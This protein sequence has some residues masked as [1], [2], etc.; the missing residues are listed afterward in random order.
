MLK[1]L[2]CLLSLTLI[3]TSV[4]PSLAQ[5]HKLG[6][7][8]KAAQQMGS[9]VTRPAA[10]HV[11]SGSIS[12]ITKK[13]DKTVAGASR[14][15]ART[16]ITPSQILNT[17]TQRFEPVH[18]HLLPPSS[19][20]TP[21]AVRIV[22]HPNLPERNLLFRSDFPLLTLNFQVQPAELGKALAVYREGLQTIS[23]PQGA[24][25]TAD[26]IT[27]ITDRVADV[28]ALGITGEST[29]DASLILATFEKSIGTAA[30]PLMTAVASRA[31]LNLSA[32]EELGRMSALSSQQPEL[33]EGIEKYAQERGLPITVASRERQAVDV[34][35]FQEPMQRYGALH[36][37]AATPDM[38]STF[39]LMNG[40]CDVVQ[41]ISNGPTLPEGF[42][43][44]GKGATS[45]VTGREDP[46]YA[47]AGD[48]VA[49]TKPVQPVMPQSVAPITVSSSS[50]SAAVPRYVPAETKDPFG[51]TVTTWKENSEHELAQQPPVTASGKKVGLIPRLRVSAASAFTAAHLFL[52]S[53]YGAMGMVAGISPVTAEA[54]VHTAPSVETVE[55]IRTAQDG[56]ISVE[57][58]T[59]G[60]SGHARM[61]VNPG[62]ISAQRAAAQTSATAKTAKPETSAAP[63]TNP[64]VIGP[65]SGI[66]YSSILGPLPELLRRW[67]SKKTTSQTAETKAKG[68]MQQANK[69]ARK[70]L[71]FVQ[72]TPTSLRAI[73]ESNASKEYKMDALLRLYEQGKLNTAING[74]PENAKAAFE[75][76]K[77]T[78]KLKEWLYNLYEMG[79]LNFAL[80]NLADHSVQ[81]NWEQDLRAI[82]ED[83]SWASKALSAYTNM[84]VLPSTAPGV[85]EGV[86]PPVP[87]VQQKEILSTFREGGFAIE[88]MGTPVDQKDVLY[89]ANRIPFYYRYADGRLSPTPVGI[90]SQESANWYGRFLSNIHLASQPGFKIP[91]G[92]VLALDESGQWKFIPA[93]GELATIENTPASAKI[94]EQIRK[95]GSYHV[96]LDTP[97]TSS[98]LLSMANMLET[99][100]DLNLELVLNTP[101]SLQQ[102]LKVHAFFIGNDAGMSLAGPFTKMLKSLPNVGA[103]MA[104]AV[105]GVGYLTPWIA[106]FAMPVMK[107]LGNVKTIQAVYGAAAAALLA[108][109]GMGLFW[110]E[111]PIG[112]EGG[113]PMGMLAVPTVA[114][115]LGASLLNTFNNT[116]LNF[117][118]DPKTRTSAHLSFAENK[119]WSRLA[120]TGLTAVAAALGGSWAVVVPV[121]LGLLAMSE[122]LFI[123]TPIY[124]ARNVKDAKA[125]EEKKKKEITAE[126]RQAFQEAYKQQIAS[127]PE[128]KDIKFRV[129]MVYASYAASLL[130]LGQGATEI[131]GPTWGPVMAAVFM[132]GTAL[133]RKGASKAIAKNKLTDD[134]MT[135]ISLPLLATSGIALTLMPY[136]GPMAALTALVGILHYMAT[137]TPGQM[138]AARLQN[139]VSA[140]MQKQKAKVLA[141]ESLTQEERSALLRELSSQEGEWASTA[142]KQ[143]SYAN[144][145]GLAGIT[146]AAAAAYLFRDLGPQWTKEILEFI[147]NYTIGTTSDSLG[148]ARIIFGYSATMASILAAKNIPLFKDFVQIFHKQQITQEN[149]D[150]GKINPSMFGMNE[151]NVALRLVNVEKE[152]SKLQDGMIEYG[153]SSE[154][155]LTKY[156]Q[157]L[158]EIYNRLVAANSLPGGSELVAPHMNNLTEL[159]RRYEGILDRNDHS[160]MLQRAFEQFKNTMF[161]ENG[162][163][164][165]STQYVEE[166]VYT[167]PQDYSKY[168]E[169]RDLVREIKQLILHDV[170]GGQVTVD[171]YT[172]IIE[173]Y[174]RVHE[175]LPAYKAA[176]M[177]DA[178][179]VLA[180]EEELNS[181]LN[182][183]KES[184]QSVGILDVQ[185]GPTKPADVQALKDLLEGVK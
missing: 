44:E 179:R 112:V 37:T 29:Q 177:A 124:K 181:I 163:L 171:T 123:N 148:L 35:Q 116:L 14:V 19:Q 140:E 121:G 22:E 10:C 34:R 138:D 137:A 169:A 60:S 101:H 80:D 111:V 107:R 146:V 45:T 160:I 151:K 133:T 12:Q 28:T 32:Y 119:Q 86:V 13:L 105:S 56:F 50:S 67:S 109:A 48:P 79:L 175:A 178:S 49:N 92:F 15:T 25:L 55:T 70:T 156:Y 128:V 142:S 125:E 158:V 58:M 31:L 157:E 97:Y 68:D 16:S 3:F 88:N 76:V 185:A 75:N 108:S 8:G 23:F 152:I 103:L 134:Q 63:T 161:D 93:A 51:N 66:L 84:S 17:A 71:A 91:K 154:Q 1:L 183:L 81:V 24:T 5:A 113:I 172:N 39:V 176:N 114:M 7:A 41:G 64:V 131:L 99:T 43:L 95:E 136:S 18:T 129:R 74:L 165:A 130:A 106:G 33:W 147:S 184:Q 182:G 65:R 90:L 155:K 143:Y 89:Y 150:A 82:L 139:I 110:K 6:R 36:V 11:P 117:F 30:E 4:T 122:L 57:E 141:D 46:L 120:L 127:M 59:G 40:E 162:A 20:F 167:L 61:E 159:M 166:G 173:Y 62:A 144:G 83:P 100:P 52:T 145:V 42:R 135:G 2:S 26:E 72:P 87:E 77:D 104:N 96:A 21:L 126:Q 54:A 78:A 53:R 73:L 174:N 94:M 38:L 164:R 168:E 170:Y 115:V 69:Q 9:R 85:Y 132:L 102:Y 47:S 180:L 98:D 149:I 27:Y 118:K 153:I